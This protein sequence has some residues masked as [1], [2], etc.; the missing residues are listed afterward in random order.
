MASRAS[1]ERALG[2]ILESE[3]RVA[4][5][6]GQIPLIPKYPPISSRYAVAITEVPNSHTPWDSIL[7]NTGLVPQ[8][9]T[10]PL[11]FSHVLVTPKGFPRN[12]PLLDAVVYPKQA[13][14]VVK[15]P[16][17]DITA[18]NPPARDSLP[19]SEVLWQ[20]YKAGTRHSNS[21]PQI[22]TLLFLQVPKGSTTHL[23]I[24]SLPPIKNKDP[25]IGSWIARGSGGLPED[26]WELLTGSDLVQPVMR[27]LHEHGVELGHPSLPR[28]AAMGGGRA[29]GSVV[30]EHLLLV[31]DTQL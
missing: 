10:S 15:N 28:F 6:K 21:E 7:H 12:A 16:Q 17:L 3:I 31:L 13:L 24:K 9:K 4:A 11:P 18:T 22:R 26:T 29:S 2:G 23:A 8:P 27:M 14:M 5:V 25:T 1:N 19:M 30:G 20:A